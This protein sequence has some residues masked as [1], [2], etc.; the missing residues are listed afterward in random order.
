[1]SD[2]SNRF[3]DRSPRSDSELLHDTARVER[4]HDG[5]FERDLGERDLDEIAA[6]RRWERDDPQG[7]LRADLLRFRCVRAEHLRWLR[8]SVRQLRAVLRRPESAD[9]ARQIA[10][11]RDA[12]EHNKESV[13]I[14]TAKVADA[15]AKLDRLQPWAAAAE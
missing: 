6:R 5:P 2:V 7:L 15:Q 14:W 1:M 8:I 11:A 10:F 12:V 3:P 4:R 13:R 9:R